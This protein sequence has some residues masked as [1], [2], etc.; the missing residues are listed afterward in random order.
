MTIVIEPYAVSAIPVI[1][2]DQNRQNSLEKVREEEAIQAS[3]KEKA[4]E[5][6]ILED[7][8]QITIADLGVESET[9]SNNLQTSLMVSEAK[10]L[11]P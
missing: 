4:K 9:A 11:I 7:F 8:S 5:K 6:E 3:G 2:V 1:P 10:K